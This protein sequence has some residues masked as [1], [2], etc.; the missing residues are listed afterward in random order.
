MAGIRVEHKVNVCLIKLSGKELSCLWQ[1]IPEV[2]KEA[3]GD[4]LVM[5]CTLQ[6]VCSVYSR[7]AL[8]KMLGRSSGEK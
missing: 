7:K 4:L 5:G 1:I 8:L 3:E 6:M 2:S